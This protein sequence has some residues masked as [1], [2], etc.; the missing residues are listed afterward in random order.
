MGI[1]K[2]HKQADKAVDQHR[3]PRTSGNAPTGNFVDIGL[4]ELFSSENLKGLF[5]VLKIFGEPR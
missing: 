5:V 2:V 3:W 4:V 1:E